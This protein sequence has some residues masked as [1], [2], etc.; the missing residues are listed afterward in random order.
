ML[1]RALPAIA[2]AALLPTAASAGGA[3]TTRIETRPY[4]GATVT[5][6]EG[7]RVFRALPPHSKVIINPGGRTPLSLHFDEYAPNYGHYGA[8]APDAYAG[9]SDN[10]GGY[11]HGGYPGSFYGG[12]PSHAVPRHSRALGYAPRHPAR[13]GSGPY[14]QPITSPLPPPVGQQLAPRPPAAQP[15]PPPAPVAPHA[16]GK[17]SGGGRH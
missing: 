15:A 16:P 2:F 4:Y 11:G 14:P 8:A 5:L 13:G 17:P 1:R 6:E 7:V 9:H 3:T 12:A 10:A